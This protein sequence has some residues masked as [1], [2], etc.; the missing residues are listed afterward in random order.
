MK[1]SG[2]GW[3]LERS[4]NEAENDGL[5]AVAVCKQSG[6]ANRCSKAESGRTETQWLQDEKCWA[7]GCWLLQPSSNCEH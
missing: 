6:G 7:T 3:E 5:L 1:R 2:I 4:V